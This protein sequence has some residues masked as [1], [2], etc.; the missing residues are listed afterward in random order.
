MRHTLTYRLAHSAGTAA[1]RFLLPLLAAA[2]LAATAGCYYGPY[3]AYYYPGYPAYGYAYA[4]A[5]VV[6]GGVVI[7][8]GGYYRRW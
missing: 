7:G 3:G 6:T 1:R 5:P 4:P 8:G 2:G